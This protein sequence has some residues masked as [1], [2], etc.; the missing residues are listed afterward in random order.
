M[1]P[2]QKLARLVFC[3]IV[4]NQIQHVLFISKKCYFTYVYIFY[5]FRG[6]RNSKFGEIKTSDENNFLRIQILGTQPQGEVMERDREMVIKGNY[7]GII[8]VAKYC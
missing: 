3:M 2:S 5:S 6:R 8:N 1:Q 4:F 7:I